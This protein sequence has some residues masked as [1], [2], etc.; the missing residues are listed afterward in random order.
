MTVL[1]DN[2]AQPAV[3]FSVTAPTA[4]R[5][6]TLKF[7]FTFLTTVASSALTNGASYG[8]YSLDPRLSNWETK[9]VKDGSGN[10]TVA[11][12]CAAGLG[13]TLTSSTLTWSANQAIT[14]TIDFS[15]ASLTVSGATTG[16][17]TV[18]GTPVTVG[19]GQWPGTLLLGGARLAGGQSPPNWAAGSTLPGL[20]SSITDDAA[21][22][23]TDALLYWAPFVWTSQNAAG[24]M[25]DN[26]VKAGSTHVRT[27]H[28]G[29]YLKLRVTVEIPSTPIA[30]NYAEPRFTA[31]DSVQIFCIVDGASSLNATVT[32]GST[33][34]FNM[35]GSLAAGTHD[36]FFWLENL[37]TSTD[38]WTTP[39]A[40]L[41]VSSI[42]LPPGVRLVAPTVHSKRMLVYGDSLTDGGQSYWPAH[43][44][45]ALDYEYG[46]AAFGGQGP[47]EAV[48]S[49]NVPDFEDSWDF[50]DSTQSRLTGG[51]LSPAPDLIIVEHGHNGTDGTSLRQAIERTLAAISAAAP[52]ARMVQLVPFLGTN[53][54]SVVNAAK[55]ANCTLLDTQSAKLVAM[56][57]WYT[58][59]QIHPNSGG[60][61]LVAAT[62]LAKYKDAFGSFGT[63]AGRRV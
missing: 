56:R 10:V 46:A 57:P 49:N 24:A 59:D 5:S 30:L 20:M 34:V 63:F 40:A 52:S 16:N 11:L 2:S 8:L 33:G 9:V 35:T 15:V 37:V 39:T 58:S 54:A 7:S 38:R 41:E 47:E 21:T 45:A 17:G 29:S 13:P 3:P 51:L 43:V 22:P 60:H 44:A 25:Q 36:L 26:N 32:D 1:Y 61:G 12:T 28:R 4:M 18:T 55:P 19:T 27:T 14:V 48:P 50:Y 23:V 31:G 62:I 6:T 42:K 53:R